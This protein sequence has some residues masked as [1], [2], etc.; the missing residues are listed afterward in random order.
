M[1]HERT[2]DRAIELLDATKLPSGRYAYWDDGMHRYY[3]V[4][5][6]DLES[7]VTL[8]VD[9]DD[10]LI[11][12]DAYSHWCAGTNADEMP[13]GWE[14]G[15]LCLTEDSITEEQIASVQ[16]EAGQAGDRITVA[17]CLVARQTTGESW[18][19]ECLDEARP[20]L[21][22]LGIVADRRDAERK[23]KAEC[24]RLIREWAGQ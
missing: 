17:I 1:T 4:D 19:R 7:Y 2:L 15:Q 3:I 18:Q 16:S 8:Y 14:P 9:H 20:Y 24:A 12:S 11:R 6:S 13:K 5:E 10:P 22:K 21:A 23:A